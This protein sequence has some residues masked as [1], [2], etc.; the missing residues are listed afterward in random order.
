MEIPSEAIEEL[1]QIHKKLTGEEF[2]DNETEEMAQ[3]L[4]QLIS[5]VYRPIP[6]DQLEKHLESYP[7]LRKLLNPATKTGDEEQTPGLK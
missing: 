1:R 4:F 5:A 6:K 3:N 7:K 2:T